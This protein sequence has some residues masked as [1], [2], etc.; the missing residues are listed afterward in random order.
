M[1]KTNLTRRGSGEIKT[2]IVAV[3]LIWGASYLYK[4]FTAPKNTT[5]TDK[6]YSEQRFN[7]ESYTSSETINACSDDSGNCY[8]VVA[9]IY[10]VFEKNGTEHKSVEQINFDN[11]GYLNFGGAPL[12]GGGTDQRGRNWSFSL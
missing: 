11:G 4:Y 2:V 5:E 10:H 9:T 12:P 3:L 7:K 6:I 8:A 1:R